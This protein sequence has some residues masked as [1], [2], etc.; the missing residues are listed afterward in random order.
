MQLAPRCQ[1]SKPT[2]TTCARGQVALRLRLS[3][4]YW[5]AGS[6]PAHSQHRTCAIG[7]HLRVSLPSV[8]R[9]RGSAESGP[10][11]RTLGAIRCGSACETLCRL[12]ASES[13]QS[14]LLDDEGLGPI[15]AVPQPAW[16]D[17]DVHDVVITRPFHAVRVLGEVSLQAAIAVGTRWNISDPLALHGHLV[18]PADNQRYLSRDGQIAVLPRTSTRVEDQLA[19]PSGRDA[20]QRRLR[21]AVSAAGSYDR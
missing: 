5:F 16:T 11:L 7:S 14:G 18:V 12:V 4:G 19:S 10:G 8:L 21:C 3:A 2:F 15:I 17:A 9:E 1:R 20:N 6:I 13:T